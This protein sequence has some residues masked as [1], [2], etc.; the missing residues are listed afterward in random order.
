MECIVVITYKHLSNM[1]LS[2][3]YIFWRVKV[4]SNELCILFPHRLLSTGA[5][6]IDSLHT[7][8]EK[9][10]R[11][12]ESQLTTIK[13]HSRIR[14]WHHYF[15]CWNY[16]LLIP[17][18]YFIYNVCWFPLVVMLSFWGNRK[19]VMKSCQLSS[20]VTHTNYIWFTPPAKKSSLVVGL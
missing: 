10:K 11:E 16:Y 8:G 7:R 20:S 3:S 19:N 18:F 12:N 9:S 17:Y 1:A 4:M 14:L 15:N 2:G 5:D 6:T 13:T